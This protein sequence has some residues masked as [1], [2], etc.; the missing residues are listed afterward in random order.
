MAEYFEPGF[1]Q[2]L[3]NV[4]VDVAT[5]WPILRDE[6]QPQKVIYDVIVQ[7][8]EE[9][10]GEDLPYC[11]DLYSKCLTYIRQY[12]AKED[13]Q[14]HRS[15][16]VQALKVHAPVILKHVWEELFVY[17]FFVHVSLQSSAME[18]VAKLFK[19]DNVWEDVSYGSDPAQFLW[20]LC[21]CS[22]VVRIVD[23]CFFIADDRAVR[24]RSWE[25]RR[26]VRAH[27]DVVPPPRKYYKLLGVGIVRERF[28]YLLSSDPSSGAL[29]DLL[30]DI[31]SDVVGDCIAHSTWD[32]VL[33]KAAA[34]INGYVTLLDDPA[35]DRKQFDICD[36]WE[37]IQ[38]AHNVI[39]LVAKYRSVQ[40]RTI[41]TDVSQTRFGAEVVA[42]AFLAAAEKNN[43]YYT[44]NLIADGR[45]GEP[46]SVVALILKLT[47]RTI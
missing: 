17:P 2:T 16:I 35:S 19:I 27:H 10:E 9:E 36:L 13:Q 42:S 39:E 47:K 45:Y 11:L 31:Q 15:S 3:Q 34:L 46:R 20:D 28:D 26:A 33:D 40:L 21:A 7:M 29:F 6:K 14:L 8:Y 5:R 18:F 43:Y 44:P 32:K 4:K 12:D 22:P 38:C 25:V 37:S 30:Q 41:L 23:H 24:Q 1:K